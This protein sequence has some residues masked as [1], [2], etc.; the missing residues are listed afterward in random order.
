MAAWIAYASWR[1]G[2]PDAVEG[3]LVVHPRLAHLGFERHLLAW[4]PPS[5]AASGARYPVVYF[6]DG[7][8]LFDPATSFAGAWHLDRALMTLAARG[9]EAI[10][11][12]I[13][14]GGTARIDEYSPF[15]QRGLGGGRAGESLRFLLEAVVPLVE[16]SFRVAPGPAGRGLFGS[17][18]GGLFALHGF[19]ERPDAFGLGGAMSPSLQWAHWAPL[20][21]L[22]TRPPRPHG[23]L[24]LDGG[25][26]EGRPGRLARWSRGLLPRPYLRGLR[27]AHAALRELGYRDGVDLLYVEEPVGEHMESA[28]S[29]RLPAAL[30]FL[31]R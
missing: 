13:P 9:I 14:N 21:Y 10:A 27:R 22:E 25:G 19:F 24:Y 7:Q 4:L 15:H 30:A 1:Q 26:R 2:P 20:V 17:S 18:L 31:L 6:L 12:G 8:N 23:R 5:Y 16:S 3:E 28:W 11:V 29:R